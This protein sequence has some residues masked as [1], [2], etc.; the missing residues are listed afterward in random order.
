MKRKLKQ[1]GS[2]TLTILILV[3]LAACS[4]DTTDESATETAVA[5]EPTTAP[6]IAP[7]SSEAE[8]Q[9]EETTETAGEGSAEEAVVA[10]IVPVENE[11]LNLN[12]ANGDDY[13]NTIPDFSNRMV[14][15]FLEYR[16]YISILQFR[17]EIGKYVNADQV[18]AYEQYVYVPVD[19]DESDAATLMQLPG[20]DE[21]VATALMAE[22]P[23]GSND[24]FL[25]ALTTYVSAEDVGIAAGYLT[26]E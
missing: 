14:R 13:L 21:A 19:V 12:E 11:R 6:T 26:S 18:A 7:A 17:Q 22:R 16:P 24:A 15:E 4:S 8:E 10:E 25:T 5:P 9:A 23:F 2:I 1:I 20:V 3:T